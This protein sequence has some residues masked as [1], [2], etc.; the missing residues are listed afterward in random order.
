MSREQTTLVEAALRECARL[1]EQAAV[2]SPAL[3]ATVAEA[4]RSAFASGGK[5]LL[6]GNG[7]SALDAQHFAAELV[8]RFVRERRALAA[9]ALTT[10]TSILTSVAN[11]YSYERVFARQVEALGRAGD[12]A[13]GISTSGTSPNVLAALRA[14]HALG[15]KTV[16]FTGRDGGTIGAMV[17]FH[18]NV[19]HTVTARVQE[20]HRSLIHAVCELVE[21]DL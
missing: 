20:V 14:A 17:D 2:Q 15:L 9:I 5:V 3:V 12:V 13:V 8:G 10:D 21:R 18:V 6:F 1:H 4:L 19:P 16:A 7:G 11:D